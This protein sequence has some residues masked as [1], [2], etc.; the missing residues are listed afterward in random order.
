VDPRAG[1]AL[2]EKKILNPTVHPV[3]SHHTDCTTPAPAMY[4]QEIALIKFKMTL[5]LGHL[6]DLLCI[7]IPIFLQKLNYTVVVE[8]EYAPRFVPV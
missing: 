7:S 1:L 2:G 6:F 8:E 5:K 3:A 4:V